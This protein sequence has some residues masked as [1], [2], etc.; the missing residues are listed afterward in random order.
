MRSG[1][2]LAGCLLLG[3]LVAVGVRAWRALDEERLH[4]WKRPDGWRR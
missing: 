1:W 2:L 3:A 4:L